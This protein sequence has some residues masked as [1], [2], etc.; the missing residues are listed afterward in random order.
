M[1]NEKLNDL[2]K[3]YHEQKLAH[4]YLIETN[5]VNRCY[6]DLKDVIKKIVCPNTNGDC[7]NCN[8]CCQINDETLPSLKIISPDGKN[9][10]K[11]DI[12]S[13]KDAFSL[14]PIYTKDNYYIIQ[15]PEKM[16]STAFNRLLKFL[17]EPEDGIYGF[18]ICLNKD[19]VAP[20]IVSRC[21]FIRYKYNE[22]DNYSEA[23]DVAKEYINKIETLKDDIIWYNNNEVFKKELDR[24]Q[25]IDL[26]KNIYQIYLDAFKNPSKYTF[27][28]SI[29]KLNVVKKY[30]EELNF[31]V[32][33]NL[34]INSFCL[35]IGALNEN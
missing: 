27:K 10:K 32:N 35:E 17:E 14:K 20:T 28:S 15:Y 25:V 11:D 21:D 30:L 13:L 3:L 8:L 16:N 29:D 6:V 19:L 26:F 2:V 18:L 24:M 7:Q 5:D 34:A 9:I 33:I 23:Y 12:D 22:I 31:N 4:A 1:H